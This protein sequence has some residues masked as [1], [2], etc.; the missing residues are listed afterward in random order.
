MRGNGKVFISHTHEDNERCA[1][2]LA[3]L[4]A[5]GVDYWFDT[6][7]LAPGQQLSDRLQ[8]AVSERD[9]FLRICTSA[10]SRSYWMSL[11]L[12]AFR[13]L[14]FEEQ[15]KTRKDGRLSINLILDPG[16]VPSLADR[17]DVVVDATNRPRRDT[18]DELRGVFGLPPTRRPK[19]GISRRGAIG[20][21]AAAV[22]TAGALTGGAVLLREENST[23]PHK[24]YPKPKVIAFDNP[25]TLDAR[26]KWYFKAG[27]TQL[28]T[29]MGMVMAKDGVYVN[30][31]DGFYALNPADGAILWMN[32]RV[33]GNSTYIP[34][35]AGDTIY[36]AGNEGFAGV[37]FALNRADGKQVWKVGTDS[38]FGDTNIAVA[39]NT[40]YT[41][42]DKGFIVAYNTANGSKRWQS[43]FD[44]GDPGINHRAPSADTTAAY[45]GSQDGNLYAFSVAD[46]SALW[47]Y[48]AGGEVTG[49]PTLANGAVYFSSKDQHVYAVS[50]AN[51]SLLWS[52]KTSQETGISPAVAN[53]VA[54]I[55]LGTNLVALDARTGKRLWQAPAGDANSF[56]FFEGP[57]VAAAGQVYG[58][59]G[60]YLY[61]F[62][63]SQKKYVW[64]LNG[65]SS[66]FSDLSA[67][68]VA[69]GDL[70][71]FCDGGVTLYALDA[72]KP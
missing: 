39:N 40:V 67:S 14:Q 8:A 38:V 48:Q 29:G 49:T 17:V 9:I 23:P 26:I 52:Y 2:L 12:N 43:A 33:R 5:W 1:P 50:A 62:S 41:L 11:E 15:R 31:D 65:S 69:T 25:Q 4:D 70:V 37:L 53:N 42:S 34:W 10:S 61:A 45:I 46:G 19:S 56:D 68:I 36:V 3:A 66:S 28:A 57:I 24:P 18:F 30:T 27:D 60:T 72:S 59:V 71:Y 63:A 6:E 58:T 35:V 32:L 51:G 55:G 21:G 22:V 20:L 54:Y 64:R 13:G 7:Q 44:V 16:Y 47:H